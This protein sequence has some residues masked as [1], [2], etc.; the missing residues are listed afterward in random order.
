VEN[1]GPAINSE[2]DEYEPLLSPDGKTMIVQA[3]SAYFQSWRQGAT[4]SPRVK[5]G[6]VIN[7]NGSEIGALFSPT[8][9]SLMFARDMKDDRSGEL[10]VLHAAPEH[11]PRP[12]PARPLPLRRP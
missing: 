3:G 4:W 12:C 2:D 7:G 9:R 10:Y 1:L 11:W 8:G 6:T 5:M